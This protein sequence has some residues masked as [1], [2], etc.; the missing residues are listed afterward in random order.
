MID[1][2]KIGKLKKDLFSDSK[3]KS[4]NANGELTKICRDHIDKLEDICS[5]YKSSRTNGSQYQTGKGFLSLEDF[6]E[7]NLYFIY[8]DN[9]QYGGHCKESITI[10]FN[11]LINFNYEGYE[12]IKGV[13]RKGLLIHEKLGLIGRLEKINKELELLNN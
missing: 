11:D 9:W 3:K 6:D 10:S 1:K 5:K 13:E 7:D 2:F 12:I 4:E 8:T